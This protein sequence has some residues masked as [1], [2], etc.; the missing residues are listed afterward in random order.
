M[1]KI[2]SKSVNYVLRLVCYY[3]TLG[4]F[5]MMFLGHVPTAGDQFQ[6][7]D[8]RFEVMDMDG[9]RVDKILVMP[10]PG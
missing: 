4:G 3:Q 10:N 1:L 7:A 2:I 8:L 9:K 6:W 5:V